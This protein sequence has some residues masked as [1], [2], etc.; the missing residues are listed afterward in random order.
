[1][2]A[3]LPKFAHPILSLEIPSTKTKANFRPFLVKEEKLLLMAKSSEDNVDILSAIKQV[4]NNCSLDPMFSVNALTIF[5]LEYLFLKLR[6][7]SIE[8]VIKVSYEDSEDSKVYDFEIDIDKI[9]VKFPKKAEPKIA[10]SGTSGIIL[11]YPS[12]SLY[13]DKI[14]LDTK[15]ETI[16]FEL[17]TRCIDQ[18]YDEKKVYLGKDYKKEEL[19]AFVEMLDVKTFETIQKFLRDSPKLEYVINYTNS[20]GSERTITLNTLADFFTLR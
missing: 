9:E 7:S 15:E 10:I 6:G 11:K 16:M 20:K 12:A 8:N 14:F 5:D 17:I 18:V 19:T 2:A 3:A 13:D 4:V 1:M